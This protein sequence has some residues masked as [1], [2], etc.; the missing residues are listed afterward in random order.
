MLSDAAMTTPRQVVPGRTYLITRRCSQRQ[1]LLRPDKRV[2]QIYY[3]ALA[4]AAQRFGITIHAYIAM[5]NHQHIVLRDNEGNF[6]E[7]LRHLNRMLAVTLNCLW[8]RWENLW[9]SEQ[10]NAVYLVD[11][12]TRFNKL[13]YVLVNAVAAD[14]VDS[15]HQWPGA[16]SLT[17]VLTG[18]AM[19]V[20]RPKVFFKADSTMPEAVTLRC[21]RLEGFEDLSQEEWQKLVT[22]AV[23]RAEQAA[24]ELRAKE[25]IRIKGRKAVVCAKPTD[26]PD[27]IAPRRGL[28]PCIACSNAELRQLEIDALRSFRAKYREMFRKWITRATDILFPAG[29]Y[30]LRLCGL[31]C[32]PFGG[33]A[34][35]LAV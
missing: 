4:E 8:G 31:P 10:P 2:N 14:L 30:R 23:A 29:T 13:I 34:L 15:C 35:S 33:A 28:R 16:H 18:E 21:E 25:G 12:Q 17:Q 1:Y 3:Y 22:D 32:A 6:P 20:T 5:G 11:A 26:T 7:F 19:T 27:T 24:R 9:S